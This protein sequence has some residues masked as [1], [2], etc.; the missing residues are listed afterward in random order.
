M[1]IGL[2]GYARVGKDTAADILVQ[3]HGF[4]RLA[5]ADALRDFLYAQNPAVGYGS[6]FPDFYGVYNPSI[7]RLRQVIDHFGW[8]GYKQSK[9]VDEI[10]PLVQRTGTE[11]GRKV[12]GENVWV[13]STLGSLDPDTNYVVT[14][15]RF[16]NEKMAIEERGGYV[17]RINRKDVGPA[18]SED[19]VIHPSETSLDRCQFDGYISNDG[20]LELLR[21]R[22]LSMYRLIGGN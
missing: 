16:P 9:F 14:D 20:D 12:I 10:R 15:A 21:K 3:E 2:S 11:A 19:G 1:I 18:Q 5:F 4:K 22:V 8:D 7:I 13:D 17:I 6:V